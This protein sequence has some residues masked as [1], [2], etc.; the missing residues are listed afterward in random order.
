MDQV[1]RNHIG[2]STALIRPPIV[3]HKPSVLNHRINTVDVLIY[4][5]YPEGSSIGR[6][7]MSNVHQ[8]Q[9]LE[10][11]AVN[12]EALQDW[13]EYRKEKKKPL[14]PMALKRTTKILLQCEDHEHQMHCVDRAIM[15]DWQGLHMVDPPKKKK[16]EIVG[17]LSWLEEA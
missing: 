15:N 13:A 11:S 7:I 6:S 16:P 4:L 17:D 12:Q 1:S 3:F 14:T 2:S 10:I 9:P 8:L 5:S